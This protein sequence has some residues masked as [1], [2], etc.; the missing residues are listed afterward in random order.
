[1]EKIKLIICLSLLFSAGCISLN[2]ES[3]YLVRKDSPTPEVSAGM[4]TRKPAVAKP[5]R[6]SIDDNIIMLADFDTG[7]K[8]NNLGGDFGAWDKD[9]DD[10]TQ[11]CN[12]AFVQE[13]RIGNTGY[14]MK[15]E[16]DVDS[17]QAAFN[18][19]WM[20]LEYAD[21][22]KMGSIA[23]SVKGD[24]TAGYTDTFAV[25]MKNSKGETGKTLILGISS[26][27]QKK[28][29][30]FSMLQGLADFSQM[31]EFVVIFDDQNTMPK[32]G[33]IYIDNI[34]VTK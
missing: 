9:P 14:S 30:P 24:K 8:P 25:E 6:P 22:S 23:F 18:G 2:E 33:V 28:V 13:E 1:M 34:H 21:F 20:K 31:T 19:F 11:F 10:T 5:V 15:L 32:T 27:W 12:A 3:G 4:Q 16:Y 17:P 26:Q 29:I 7:E